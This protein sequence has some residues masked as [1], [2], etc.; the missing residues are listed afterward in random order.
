MKR[1]KSD[2]YFVSC[3]L[4]KDGSVKAIDDEG[5]EFH[6]EMYRGDAWPILSRRGRRF[7][8]LERWE[9]RRKEEAKPTPPPF[10]PP[11]LVKS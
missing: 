3:E 2:P 6:L 8:T 9:Q 10:G 11:R 7:E 5:E 4:L 1:R